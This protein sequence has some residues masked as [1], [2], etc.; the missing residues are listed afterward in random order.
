ML[1]SRTLKSAMLAIAGGMLLGNT[2]PAEIE[3]LMEE[4]REA[5]AFALVEKAADAGSIPML[6][7][8]AW[9]YDEGRGVAEDDAKAAQLYRD[10]AA[11]GHP[12]AQ[13][14]LGM[15]IDAGEAPGELFEAVSLFK[16]AVY[17]GNT[18][19]MT[20]LAVMYAT[21]RGVE[22][23]FDQTRM[24]YEMAARQG[25]A[26][27]VQGLGV[28]FAN[29]QGV[30]KNMGEAIAYWL[31]ASRLGSL[32]ATET[33]SPLIGQ[34]DDEQRGD[35]TARANELIGLLGFQGTIALDPVG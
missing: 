4:G 26:H 2:T 31:I 14:R 18:N 1:G 22:Q 17:Q 25:N 3:R 30:E 20:S 7:N 13:W 33:L 6:T 11:S 19:A 35:V 32:A 23:D 27:A 15:M 24:Y 5:E 10:A 29:G 9:M 21:G 8:L 34:L 16:Q 28:L 12:F